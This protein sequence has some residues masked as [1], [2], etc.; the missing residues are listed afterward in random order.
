MEVTCGG[1]LWNLIASERACTDQA[2][3]S[4]RLQVA[5]LVHLHPAT[6]LF[7]PHSRRLLLRTLQLLL[8]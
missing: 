8:P 5:Y 7:F 6:A 1:G 3:G 4:W 2:E